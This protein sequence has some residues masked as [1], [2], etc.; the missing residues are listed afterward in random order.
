[1]K[2]VKIYTLV[3]TIMLGSTCAMA[4]QNE[5]IVIGEKFK[6][7]SNILGGEREIY[8]S[9][10]PKYDEHLQ[11]FPVVFVLE[12]EFLFETTKSITQLLAM[13]SEMPSSIIVGIPNNTPEDRHEYTI[14]PHGG[15]VY[16]HLK[17]FRNEL[18]PYIE[19]NYR[20]NKHRTIIG[21][22]PTTGLVFEAFWGEPDLFTGYIGLTTHLVWNPRKG[23]KMIDKLIS[24]ITDPNH[25]K[26]AIYFVT[27]DKDANRT[28]YAQQENAEAVEKLENLPKINVRF[29][30]EILN[31]DEHYA[32]VPTG[33]RNAFKLIYPYHKSV[34]T[35]YRNSEKAV[36][37]YR[38]HYKSLSEIYGFEM[39][40]VE[41]GAPHSD[42]ISGF[43]KYL[44]RFKNNK[45]AIELLRLGID[46]FPNSANLHMKLAEAYKREGQT[47]LAL[48]AA[49]KSIR[50]AI[51]Y[52]PYELN[53]FKEAL[54]NIEN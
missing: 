30:F 45:D 47:D 42:S 43:A 12:A 2:L 28:A 36:E 51:K 44:H 32:V 40:P 48:E 25:P 38:K 10:P 27:A 16:D 34:F 5:Q 49:N 29:K 46:Y 11:D 41:F 1:M 14:L 23:V 3:I 13:R 22:S 19:K 35:T 20:A 7:H 39:Y 8:I 26:A 33:I 52:R 54:K 6:L 53:N 21:L 24:G 31:N 18:I 37:D 9:L 17:F 4:Q 15:R 50:L